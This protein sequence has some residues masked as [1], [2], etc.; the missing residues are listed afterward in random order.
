VVRGERTV[1]GFQVLPG[2]E[3]YG[4][5]ALTVISMSA[6]LAQV[7]AKTKK[8]LLMQILANSAT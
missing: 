7:V 6:S 1:R 2:G 8:N 3:R 5:F 4:S